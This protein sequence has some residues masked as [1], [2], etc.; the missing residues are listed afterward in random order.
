[1]SAL[2]CSNC[3]KENH[4][5]RE[6]REPLTSYGL[7][8]YNY[9]NDEV[10][11]EYKVVMIRRKDTI[12]YVEFLR[13]KYNIQQQNSDYDIIK[14]EDVS[15]NAIDN[16][17]EKDEP[18]SVINNEVIESIQENEINNHEEYQNINEHRLIK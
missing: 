18:Q 6:C 8:C 4:L 3:G 2:V 7:I 14:L 16:K 10:N 12:G 5:Q 17:K 1:M 13:G 9:F 15:Q 11:P